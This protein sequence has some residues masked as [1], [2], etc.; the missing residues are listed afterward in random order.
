M[1]KTAAIMT[2]AMLSFATLPALAD[3]GAYLEITMK[4]ND[5]DRA[6]AAGVYT[7]YKQPF[8]QTISGAESKSLLVRK[9]DVQVLHGFKT[10]KAAE[11]YL[12]TELFSADVVSA[13]KP[14][15]QAAPEI[16]IYSA[17]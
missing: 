6:A 7:K 16:R 14:Y 17:H 13:L 4:V 8:L 1:I 9:D 15:F 2:A 10:V 5:A 12:K 3:P 11:A